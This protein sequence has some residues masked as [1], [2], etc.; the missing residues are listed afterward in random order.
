MLAHFGIV[1]TPDSLPAID[2]YYAQLVALEY[3]QDLTPYA[4]AAGVPLAVLSGGT[5]E[6]SAKAAK[7]MLER[8]VKDIDIPAYGFKVGHRISMADHGILGYAYLSC[9]TARDSLETYLRYQHLLGT[10]GGAKEGLILD[11]ETGTI[12][13][14]VEHYASSSMQQYYAERLLGEWCSVIESIFKESV[15]FSLVRLA[16]PRPSYHDELEECVGCPV[17]YDCS[18]NEYVMPAR[19][20][21]A[22]LQFS[23]AEVAELSRQQCETALKSLK[24]KGGMAESVC[25]YLVGN[26]GNELTAESVSKGLNISYRSLRRRLQEEGT[27][28]RE[29]YSRV[30]MQLAA[31]FLVQTSMSVE[32]VAEEVGYADRSSFQST[33][34]KWSGLTPTQYRKQNPY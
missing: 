15:S 20:L 11:G 34:K 28:F 12:T 5:T 33:F 9:K 23:D 27:S 17:E 29:L 30:R 14:P 19:F 4:E 13:S 32:Q 18:R 26:P 25:R 16:C 8:A 21:D 3:G 10:E 22:P 1:T 6:V 7:S 24:S 2:V 31:E